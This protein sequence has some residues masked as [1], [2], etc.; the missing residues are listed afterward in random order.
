MSVFQHPRLGKTRDTTDGHFTPT[1]PAMNK[2]FL[3]PGVE[4]MVLLVAE[5]TTWDGAET[6]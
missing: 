5:I 4:S 3:D 6:L 1:A 2:Y